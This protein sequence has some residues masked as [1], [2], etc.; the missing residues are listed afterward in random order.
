[1]MVVVVMVVERR[2]C[3]Y[4]SSWF[5]EK[6]Y[7][8]FRSVWDCESDLNPYLAAAVKSFVRFRRE[9]DKMSAA[10]SISGNLTHKSLTKG[11]CVCVSLYNNKNKKDL[12][13]RRVSFECV[14]HTVQ[15]KC[16]PRGSLGVSIA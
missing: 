7:H 14:F 15:S 13:E 3:R 8:Y 2:D 12:V 1:M 10:V 11:V 5:D 4:W 16:H 6:Y 9:R